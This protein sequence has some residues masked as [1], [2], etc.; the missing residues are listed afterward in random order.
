V[1]KSRCMVPSRTLHCRLH[2]SAR[3]SPPAGTC[4]GTTRDAEISIDATRVG[5]GALVA[6]ETGI[7]SRPGIRLAHCLARM[8]AGGPKAHLE[9]HSGSSR[10]TGQRDC[11]NG[12]D[13]WAS[14]S[15]EAPN[16]IGPAH[17][18]GS[19]AWKPPGGSANEELLDSSSD[20]HWC[21]R[22]A[23]LTAWR[24]TTAP[25]GP[26]ATSEAGSLIPGFGLGPDGHTDRDPRSREGPMRVPS[27]CLGP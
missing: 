23:A 8:D 7:S 4:E 3:G 18:P 5:T 10:G 14:P 26:D 20:R 21:R 16:L 6:W 17:G 15:G 13:R 1:S 22:P 11:G 24:T 2:V 19:A 27:S 25:V 12:R 9:V